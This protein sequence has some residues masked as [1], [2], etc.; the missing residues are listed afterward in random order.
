MPGSSRRVSSPEEFG[1]YIRSEID[2]WTKVARAANVKL[3]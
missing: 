3:D 1:A 2:K